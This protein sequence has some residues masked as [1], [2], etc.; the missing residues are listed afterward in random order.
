MLRGRDFCLIISDGYFSARLIASTVISAN[1]TAR[2]TTFLFMLLLLLVLVHRVSCLLTDSISY[3][4][5]STLLYSTLLRLLRDKSLSLMS[6]S[7]LIVHDTSFLQIRSCFVELHLCMY[8][9]CPFWWTSFWCKETQIT[10]PRR[11]SHLFRSSSLTHTL[12]EHLPDGPS[13]PI[14]LYFR[15]QAR[16]KEISD[17]VCSCPVDAPSLNIRETYSRNRAA[18]M[19]Q[20]RVKALSWHISRHMLHQVAI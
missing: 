12:G 19:V 6:A 9:I 7:C 11:Q 16:H 13:R 17:Q 15:W 1:G 4:F 5:Y 3:S 8:P 14:G 2:P 10:V 18:C 20:V